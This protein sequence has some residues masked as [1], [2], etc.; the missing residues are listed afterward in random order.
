M[1]SNHIVWSIPQ[2]HND[3]MRRLEKP[4]ALV[5]PQHATTSEV[6]STDLRCFGKEYLQI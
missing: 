2:F 4:I 3:H 6:N 1:W 5:P